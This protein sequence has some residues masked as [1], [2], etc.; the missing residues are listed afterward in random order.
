M[1]KPEKLYKY[2]PISV[3]SLLNLKS[4]T[5][6]FGAPINF[7]DPYDCAIGAKVREPSDKE[8]EEFRH[9]YSQIEEIPDFT[10]TQLKSVPRGQLKTW[11]MRV[12]Q[13]SISQIIEENIK[14]RG[15]TCFSE[16]N[17]E[18]LMWS[19]YAA[20]YTGFCLEFNTSYEPFSKVRK[21]IYRKSMPT[22]SVTDALVN[23]NYN[24][25]LELYC[26]KSSSWDYEREWRCIHHV[27]G[28]KWTYEPV[29]LSG[30]YFGPEIDPRALEIICLILQGQNSSV[31]F[32][33]GKRSSETFSVEFKSF[34]YTSHLSAKK[35]GMIT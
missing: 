34:E 5:L 29:A 32:W 9:Q 8:I 22:L 16:I 15:V 27:A 10:R 4:Q 35:L 2:E 17:N 21:V 24:Q 7:N 23:K 28:T 3:Q 30:V 31:K 18:L 20:K 13:Q 19:H 26:T 1:K 6:Y 12:G 11:L 25:F 33:Q 14:N